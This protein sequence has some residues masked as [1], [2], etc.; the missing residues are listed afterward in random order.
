MKVYLGLLIAL[1]TAFVS[2]IYS[3]GISVFSWFAPGEETFVK[4]LVLWT[5]TEKIITTEDKRLTQN[6][7]IIR[8]PVW[9]K[10]ADIQRKAISF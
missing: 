6:L 2:L 7:A 3:S 8:W 1:R 9:L 4:S 5:A 10:N